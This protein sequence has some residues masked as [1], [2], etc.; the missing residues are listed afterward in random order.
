MDPDGR[1]PCVSGPPIPEPEASCE[2]R[3]GEYRPACEN[4]LHEHE[5]TRLV[6]LGDWG[7]DF[8]QPTPAFDPEAVHNLQNFAAPSNQTVVNDPKRAS[9]DSVGFYSR[10]MSVCA[11]FDG[12]GFDSVNFDWEPHDGVEQF[13][14]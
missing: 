1:Q 4:V 5:L 7:L 2:L 8:P 11:H 10:D 14:V 6:C 9:P 12:V 13:F 3:E